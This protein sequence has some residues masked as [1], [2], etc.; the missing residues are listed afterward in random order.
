MLK[1]KE[2]TRKPT[3][4]AWSV[5]VTLIFLTLGSLGGCATAVGTT[6]AVLPP[7]PSVTIEIESYEPH[8]NFEWD[9]PRGD[10]TTTKVTSRGMLTAIVETSPAGLPVWYELSPDLD[11]WVPIREPAIESFL[12]LD[13]ER[14]VRRVVFECIPTLGEEVSKR[15]FIR[16]NY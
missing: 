9:I 10:G 14:A 7:E 15:Q 4:I 8:K 6:E 2:N 12:Y 11:N 5:K 16:V 3:L 13:T 1:S